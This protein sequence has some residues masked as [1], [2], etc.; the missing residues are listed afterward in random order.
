MFRKEF[1]RCCDIVPY[2]I[3]LGLYNYNNILHKGK[4]YVDLTRQN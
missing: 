2:Y 4:Q 1:K 3:N